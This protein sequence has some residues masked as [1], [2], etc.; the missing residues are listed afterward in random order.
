MKS[1]LDVL[2]DVT[3][4]GKVKGN[5]TG[6]GTKYLFSKNFRH[7]L[8]EGFPLLT[9]KKINP[10]RVLGELFAF[11][12]G[13]T[14]VQEFEA[15]GSNIWEPWG[16]EEDHYRLLK[17]KVSDYAQ[18]IADKLNISKEQGVDKL[19]D[20]EE[21][22]EK[23]QAEYSAHVTAI[24][25]G[26]ISNPEEITE[27]T[28]ALLLKQPQ[29]VPQYLKSLDIP[30]YVKDIIYEKG[31][32]GPIYGEQWLNWKTSTG[33]VI[34]Q[35]KRVADQLEF[36]PSSRRIVLTAWNPEV[37]PADKYTMVGDKGRPVLNSSDG[38]QAA[39]LDGK[40]ALPPCHLLV[41]LDI[42]RDDEE[43]E[44]VL[45]M[46]VIMRSTDVPVGLPFNIASYAFLM[47][48]IAKQFG[49]VAGVLSIDMT[50]CHIYDDQL[51]LAKVQMARIPKK[52]PTLTIPDGIEFDRPETLTRAKVEE[53]IAGIQNY[54]HDAFIKYPVAV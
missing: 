2:E 22:F 8:R 35:L 53:I 43:M 45:N 46:H 52:L 15:L 24:S 19:R 17:A 1:Y 3:T 28:N 49:M 13:A 9:T 12:R 51:E 39:I 29:T 14:T 21:A 42:D 4:K 6:V 50:N 44:A 47:E 36:F 27:T 32:L 33:D 5:R 41:I 16:L 18:L 26:E 37:I 23:W 10:L 40:Q 54:E 30:L 20:V 25:S 7:D 34:N 11:L 48:I 31:Y 38:V